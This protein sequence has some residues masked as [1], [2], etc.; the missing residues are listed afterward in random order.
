MHVPGS[1]TSTADR[2]SEVYGLCG[3]GSVALDYIEMGHMHK[4]YECS[5]PSA[6]IATLQSHSQLSQI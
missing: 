1:S 6:S 4:L 5:K 2:L 3:V